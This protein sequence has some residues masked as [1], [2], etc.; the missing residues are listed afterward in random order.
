MN[1][2]MQIERPLSADPLRFH[3]WC[4]KMDDEREGTNERQVALLKKE[5]EY[6]RQILTG[7][8]RPPLTI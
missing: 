2:L 3:P 8:T 7:N 1:L 4:V 6:E 5:Y